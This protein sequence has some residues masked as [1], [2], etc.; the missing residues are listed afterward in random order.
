M[1]I[2]ICNG[3]CVMCICGCS[4][5]TSK[6]FYFAIGTIYYEYFAIGGG[7]SALCIVYIYMYKSTLLFLLR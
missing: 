5:S 1:Q 6:S 4:K 2:C 3:M 7:R